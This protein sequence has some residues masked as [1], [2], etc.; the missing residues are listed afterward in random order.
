LKSA[1]TST[2]HHFFITF[3]YL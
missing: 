1:N 3:G 2:W